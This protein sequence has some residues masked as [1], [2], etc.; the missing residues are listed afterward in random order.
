MAR[1]KKRPKPPVPGESPFAGVPRLLQAFQDRAYAAKF[2]AFADYNLRVA[3]YVDDG[4]PERDA[5]ALAARE[6]LKTLQP[7]L[8]AWRRQ[9][10][11]AARKFFE[12]ADPAVLIVDGT[13]AYANQTATDL[14]RKDLVGKPASLIEKHNRT[15]RRAEDVV[16]SSAETPFRWERGTLTAWRA[17]RARL[18]KEHPSFTDVKIRTAN[19]LAD[20]P[21]G[22]FFVLRLRLWADV[23][24]AVFDAASRIAKGPADQYEGRLLALLGRM[25]RELGDALEA[26]HLKLVE[27]AGKGQRRERRRAYRAAFEKLKSGMLASRPRKR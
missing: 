11:A 10:I 15:A 6:T 5:Q 19:P 7:D 25:A 14:L 8:D 16:L 9:T 1:P 3:K 20:Q 4:Y 12:K 26:R 18:A 22:N 21:A 13:V 23:D 17:E 24:E 2:A 27:F